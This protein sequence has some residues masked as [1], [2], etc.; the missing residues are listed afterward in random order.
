MFDI[1]IT[2]I[3]TQFQVLILEFVEVAELVEH[4]R[5]INTVQ[6]RIELLLQYY[7]DFVGFNIKIYLFDTLI[8]KPIIELYIY[9]SGVNRLIRDVIVH[10]N[11]KAFQIVLCTRLHVWY[12]RSLVYYR[13]SGFMVEFVMLYLVERLKHI[14]KIQQ[15]METFCNNI[16]LKS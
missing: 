9:N 2:T 4:L 5:N 3:N 15:Q 10:H 13:V 8:R 11:F 6:H 7:G 1:K 16:F 12:L 14:I